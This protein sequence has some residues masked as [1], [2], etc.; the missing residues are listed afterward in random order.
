[1]FEPHA[2]GCEL[3]VVA[4]DVVGRQ[5]ERDAATGLVADPGDLVRGSRPR[6]Q[7]PRSAAAERSNHDP[8]L[9]LVHAGVLEQPEAEHVDVE[10]DRLVV[11]TD[12][13]RHQVYRQHSPKRPYPAS[14]AVEPCC[15]LPTG[16]YATTTAPLPNTLESTSSSADGMVP[17]ANSRF[18]LPI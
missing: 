11:V 1:L 13:H 8:A 9:G 7:Q 16:R 5:E 12:D 6:E 18:P 15:S 10:R 17:S 4:V 2:G 3:L 14:S